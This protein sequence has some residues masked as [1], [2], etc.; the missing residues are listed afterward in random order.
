MPTIHLT[1]A[2]Y[3]VFNGRH[4]E[5][6]LQNIHRLARGGATVIC[7]QEARRVP[8]RPFIG[9]QAQKKLGRGWGSDFF[10][11]QHSTFP[12]RDLGLAIFWRSA[13][14]QPLGHEHIILPKIRRYN[15]VRKIATLKSAPAQRG[16]M[17]SRFRIGHKTLRLI[18]VHLDVMGGMRHRFLQIKYLMTKANHERSPNF[19]IVCG[20]FNTIG[21]KFWQRREEKKLQ[22]ILGENFQDASIHLPYSFRIKSIQK[23]SVAHELHLTVL[24]QKV[25]NHL[26]PQRLD[27]IWNRGLHVTRAHV[28]HLEGSDHLPVVADFQVP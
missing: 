4:P 28:V 24:L 25:V 3:N 19:D 17:V 6:V 13:V 12:K 21:P 20:D 14:L 22:A 5:A 11:A 2:T 15:L 16:A 27:Y 7:L 8:G 26:F 18:N 9:H 1:V 23:T 10:V